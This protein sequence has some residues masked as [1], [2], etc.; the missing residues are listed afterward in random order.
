MCQHHEHTHPKRARMYVRC[1][2]NLHA[3]EFA[4]NM[5]N[6]PNAR[7]AAHSAY[8]PATVRPKIKLKI[9]TIEIQPQLFG[10]QDRDGVT[11]SFRLFPLGGFVSFP[12]GIEEEVR[13]VCVC[14]C[15]CVFTNSQKPSV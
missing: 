12:E 10:F 5:R 11:Y 14:V 2:S 8:S 15:V 9:V 7:T 3:I 4:S 13:C 6:T 1:T